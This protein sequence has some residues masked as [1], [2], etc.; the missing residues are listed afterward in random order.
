MSPSIAEPGALAGD[1]KPDTPEHEQMVRVYKVAV[2]RAAK[3][4]QL[5]ADLPQA[6]HDAE[7]RVRDL[8]GR[9]GLPSEV[10]PAAT[11]RRRVGAQRLPPGEVYKIVLA[12]L[13]QPRSSAAIVRHTGMT[14]PQ[15]DSAL[16][17]MRAEGQV[18]KERS[19][20]GKWSRVEAA[21]PRSMDHGST[22]RCLAM[23]PPPHGGSWQRCTLIEGHERPHMAGEGL[24]AYTWPDGKPWGD[25]DGVGEDGGPFPDIPTHEPQ[26]ARSDP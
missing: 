22:S 17:K 15:V 7:L 26:P 4:R 6:I 25:P 24:A 12:Q 8:A 21:D 16:K 19:Y 13:D 9:L 14:R 10:A 1:P 20:G 18:V 2:A 5:E 11:T 3:L 23:S